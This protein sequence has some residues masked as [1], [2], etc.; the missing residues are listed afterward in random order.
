MFN[1][2]K[3]FT[4]KRPYVHIILIMIA[5]SF[6][7]VSI[8]YIV[9]KNFIGSGLYTAIFLTLIELLRVRRRNKLKN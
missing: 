1:K 5:T 6:I 3:G 2:Y 8:E 7:G 9:N 4:E